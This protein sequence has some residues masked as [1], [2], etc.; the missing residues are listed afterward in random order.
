MGDRMRAY[1]ARAT[2]IAAVLGLSLTLAACSTGPDPV[3]TRESIEDAAQDR[4]NTDDVEA[5]DATLH[6]DPLVDPGECTPYLVITARGTGEPESGQLLSPVARLISDARPGE[7]RIQDLD[8]P[9]DTDVKRGSAAG[10]RTLIDTLNVQTDACPD[11]QF[12]LLGY[13]QG[14]L[15]VGDALV[16][17]GARVVGLRVGEILPAAS[18]RILAV[19]LYGDP[20]FQSEESF[21]F[22]DSVPGHDGVFP[23]PVG[24]LAA[25]EERVR[26]YCVADDIVCQTTLDLEETGHTAYF[27][28]GMQADGA[29]FVITRLPEHSGDDLP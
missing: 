16:D 8:Y 26:D 24:S 7:V 12:V 22:G 20:R 4:A 3:E 10:V 21:N 25:Y 29:A 6:P 28:N 9:A 13:S 17:P 23:R 15:I 2:A 5:Y 11:Q 19:L 1:I 14:A 18:G 27:D